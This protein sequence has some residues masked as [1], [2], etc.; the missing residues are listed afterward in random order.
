MLLVAKT[1]VG[2]ASASAARIVKILLMVTV[3]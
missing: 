1:A 3:S 2:R